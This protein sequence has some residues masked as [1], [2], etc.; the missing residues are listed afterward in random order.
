MLN[1]KLHSSG[2]GQ[3]ALGAAA[4]MLLVLRLPAEAQANDGD[5]SCVPLTIPNP[6]ELVIT[7]DAPGSAPGDY[8]VTWKRSAAKWPSYLERQ[9]RSS[10]RPASATAGRD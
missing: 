7:W 8:R 10:L 3:A 2:P 1:R 9:H 6:G 4:A 5:A